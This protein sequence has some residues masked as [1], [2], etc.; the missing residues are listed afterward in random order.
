LRK[1]SGD[2]ERVEIPG[3]LLGIDESTV[4][5][6]KTI[7]FT[8][9]DAIVMITDGYLEIKVD[10]EESVIRQDDFMKFAKSLINT[11]SLSATLFENS[12]LRHFSF[13]D[14]VDDRTVIVIR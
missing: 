11:E 7:D 14:F 8:P 5:C 13:E 12:F 9:G 10:G 4:F 3:K 2:V 6:N 1:S